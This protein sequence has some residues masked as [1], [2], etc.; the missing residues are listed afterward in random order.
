MKMHSLNKIKYN[1]F[2]YPPNEQFIFHQSAITMAGYDEDRSQPLVEHGPI[3][4]TRLCK[5]VT[6]SPRKGA[7]V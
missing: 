3:L 1:I 6:E 5:S 4:I 7:Q 2:I